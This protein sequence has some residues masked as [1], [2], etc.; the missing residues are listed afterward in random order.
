MKLAIILVLVAFASGRPELPRRLMQQ[1]RIN[2][3]VTFNEGTRDVLQAIEDTRF[4]TR[5]D[6]LWAIHDNLKML[7]DRVQAN[8]KA[9]AVQGG[10]EHQVLW[11]TNQLAVKGADAKL[12]M[13]L[14]D[15]PEVTDVQQEIVIPLEPVIVE[16]PI[17]TGSQ[18]QREDEWGVKK[19]QA[20]EAE[21]LLDSLAV[22]ASEVRVATIDTGV[23]YTH[24]AL[25]NNWV[26]QYGWFDPYDFN[27][28]PM[29]NN[30]HGKLIFR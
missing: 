19:V 9:L 3:V 30:G 4:D 15:L 16:G 10:F 28:L 23:R 2:I 24:E 14:Y 25:Y 12:V 26:G 5:G 21:Q 8:A 1:D 22:T 13:D 20:R 27:P 7:A 29:D 11:I 6:L 18:R 17:V